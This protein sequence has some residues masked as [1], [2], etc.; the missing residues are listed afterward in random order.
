MICISGQTECGH[1]VDK[2]RHFQDSKKFVWLGKVYASCFIMFLSRLTFFTHLI[3]N[4]LTD[5]INTVI[6]TCVVSQ[7]SAMICGRLSLFCSNPSAN[8]P[9]T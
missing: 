7:N 3:N 2:T 4:V 6:N 1:G 8:V 9:F 5:V